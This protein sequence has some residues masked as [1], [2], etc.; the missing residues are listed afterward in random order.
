MIRKDLEPDRFSAVPGTLPGAYVVPVA[1]PEAVVVPRGATAFVRPY[2]RALPGKPISMHFYSDHHYFD[3]DKGVPDAVHEFE[4]VF[5]SRQTDAPAL[6]FVPELPYLDGFYV[7]LSD[8]WAVWEEATRLLHVFP[9]RDEP[10]WEH[11]I[12]IRPPIEGQADGDWDY[13]VR[14]GRVV[15]GR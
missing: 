12:R 6:I 2:P 8:G 14:D 7:W 5:A 4:V 1:E 15:T 11:R 10:G 13:F 9:Q 3:P